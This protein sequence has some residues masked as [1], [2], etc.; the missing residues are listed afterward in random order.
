MKIITFLLSF[1]ATLILIPQVMRFSR[2]RNILDYPRA[3]SIHRNPVPMLGGVIIFV[4]FFGAC[5]I[6][7]VGSCTLPF[8]IASLVI[9]AS[10]V[11]D[12]IKGLRAPQKL[13]IQCLSA[14]ILVS[15]GVVMQRISIPFGPVVE[16][17][18]FAVPATILWFILMTNLINIVDGLDGL[19]A[20]LSCIILFVLISFMWASAESA[21]L[22]ILLGAT[23]AFL[24]FNFHPARIFLGN[25]GSAFL[26]FAIA[27]FALITS[28]KSTIVP[29]LV[30]PCAI[31]SIH[32]VDIGYAIVRRTSKK[33]SIFKGDKKHLHHIMLN[34]VGSHE[35]AV[36]V[37]YLISLSLALAFI[38]LTRQY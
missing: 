22:L 10:G 32:V 21:E 6:L 20:G 11:Y 36:L 31:L 3:N 37:F 12:D 23:S 13:L 35:L 38:N 5:L 1:S 25:N 4:V 28:Q 33:I 27:Y 8:F 16:L 29:I 14:G 34:V 19:A 2:K 24:I 17:G 15:F 7:K 18:I 9:V 30:L 26:G